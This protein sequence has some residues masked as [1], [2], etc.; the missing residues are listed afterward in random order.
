[1]KRWLSTFRP[2]SRLAVLVGIAVSIAANV[3][4]SLITTG[5]PWAHAGAAFW[6]VALLIALE[7]VARYRTPA[8]WRLWA[9]RLSL[10]LVGAVAFVLSYRHMAGLMDGFGEDGFNAHVGPLA[11]DGLMILAAVTLLPET[12]TEARTDS[13]VTLVEQAHMTAHLDQ[14]ERTTA[15]LGALAVRLS[16]LD[17]QLTAQ[18]YFAV[19]AVERLGA[20]PYPSGHPDRTSE[21]ETVRTPSADGDRTPPKSP[22]RTPRKDATRTP[23]GQG[24]RTPDELVLSYV[25]E[26]RA[27]HGEDPSPTRL[28]REMN[29][30][31][32]RGR[33]LIEQAGTPSLRAVQP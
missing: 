30:S 19:L 10:G 5:D 31:P 17:R 15:Q 9:T 29:V 32:E 22:R 8:R 7:I 26:Y 28:K 1:M 12:E 21:P 18:A 33:K 6:P 24:G 4:H 13:V 2:Y 20:R 27:E 11:V 16:N 14:F 25:R 23:S 3:R